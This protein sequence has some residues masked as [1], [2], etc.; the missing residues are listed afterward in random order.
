MLHDQV[1]V[2]CEFSMATFST[3]EDEHWH[4]GNHKSREMTIYLKQTCKAAIVLQLLPALP[5]WHRCLDLASRWQEIWCL[6]ECSLT[7]CH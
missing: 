2:N 5:D 4:H 3:S 1:L 6:G 7:S